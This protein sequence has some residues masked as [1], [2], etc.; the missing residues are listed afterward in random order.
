MIGLRLSVPA[1]TSFLALTV[2]TGG[3]AQQAHAQDPSD[4]EH[5]FEVLWQTFDRNYGIFGPKRVD[6]GALYRVYRPLVTGETTDDELFEIMSRLLGHLNDNHVSLAGGGRQYRSGILSELNG[7]GYREQEMEDFSLELVKSEYLVG[8]LQEQGILRFGWLPDSIGYLRIRGFSQL[9]Q[10]NQA[11]DEVMRV[12]QG[13]RSIVVDLRATPGGDDR[14]GK[15]I[16]DRFADRK[17]LYMKTYER[18]GPEHDDFAP[19]K[20]FYVEPSGPVQFTR[21]MVALTNRWGISAA[22]NFALAMRALPHVTLIG[23]FTSGVFADVYGDQL[24]N[25]WRFSVSYKLFVDNT[26]FCWEGIGV[27]A[28]LRIINRPEDIAAG[29]DRVLDFALDFIRRGEPSPKDV[30]SGL[31]DVRDS[32]SELLEL[33]LEGRAADARSFEAAVAA[34]QEALS[35][36]PGAYYVDEDELLALAGE[37]AAR[38]QTDAAFGVLRLAA[39]S[40]PES[41]RSW[42]LL[43][44]RSMQQ[45]DEA[46]AREEF[47]EMLERN[48]RSYP[49][50][51]QAAEVADAVLSGRKILAPALEHSATDEEFAAELRSFRADPAAY[52]FDESGLNSLG[53]R[54]LQG[55]QVDRAIEVFLI[56]T[57]HFPGSAN[58][59]DSLGDGYRAKGDTAQAIAS[60]R[61]AL[62]VDPSFAASLQNLAELTGRR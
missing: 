44:E 59:F 48:R 47:A 33:E 21:P 24:P 26:E 53:Y 8:Q 17:R 57:E 25:G 40:F 52:Y 35:A 27:P 32:W 49:W 56:N 19:P 39:E 16:A 14:V 34:A 62:E 6:W 29:H 20:Y 12:F 36:E 7:D 38:G 30:S 22:E 18:N 3:G 13:A 41:P 54:L 50:E 1:L 51:K 45:G 10:T 42:Q 9:A 61:K 60:Y 43:A 2:L 55:G 5:N 23:D 11:T 37:L 31:A 4:P 58:V 28:D 15:A 46:A